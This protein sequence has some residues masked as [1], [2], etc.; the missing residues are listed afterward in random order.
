MEYTIKPNGEFKSAEIYF[1]EKP[2]ETVRAALKAAGFRW[3]GL[4]KCWYGKM[5]TTEANVV[6]CKATGAIPDGFPKMDAFDSE[7][8]EKMQSAIKAVEK[9]KKAEVKAERIDGNFYTDEFL[10]A[11]PEK[12]PKIGDVVE[13]IDSPAKSV[14]GMYYVTQWGKKNVVR[15]VRLRPEKI[16]PGT[17]HKVV[18]L[19]AAA[20]RLRNGSRARG[21]Q[22][23]YSKVARSR[24]G[25]RCGVP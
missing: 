7:T 20:Q 18:S 5:T 2:D 4:K 21:E 10:K 17:G 6:I 19:L 14:N 9:I 24:P 16:E 15:R 8:A 3:H 13:V 23:I 22:E 12:A 11:H 1:D 25:I